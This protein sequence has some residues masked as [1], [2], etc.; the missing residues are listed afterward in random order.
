MAERG[1]LIPGRLR[2]ITGLFLLVLLISGCGH[3]NP[4]STGTVVTVGSGGG[5]AVRA[6]IG[7]A[8]VPQAGGRAL[9]DGSGDALYMFA[10]DHRRKVTCGAL[11]VNSWPPVL[12]SAADDVSA[13][14]GVDQRLVETIAYQDGARVVTYN[15]WPLY[16][17]ASDRS[18]HV[19]SG[20][21]LDLNGGYWYLMSPDGSP[22]VPSGDP[23]P[24][25]SAR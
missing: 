23:Q 4:G 14:A 10:P 2:V 12:V 8:I 3:S 24:T 5:H 9:V 16:T 22:I 6:H 11:C 15:R 20:Q 7:V 21:G 17:Y 18:P 19:G 1:Q 13:G 25:S